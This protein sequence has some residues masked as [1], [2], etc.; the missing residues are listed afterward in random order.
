MLARSTPTCSTFGLSSSSEPV[1]A[2][3]IDLPRVYSSVLFSRNLNACSYVRF[4]KHTYDSYETQRRSVTHRAPRPVPYI[5]SALF[6]PASTHY[7]AVE[8]APTYTSSRALEHSL[9]ASGTRLEHRTEWHHAEGVKY[10]MAT[11]WRAW[12]WDVRRGPRVTPC[13]ADLLSHL[14]RP[15]RA[16]QLMVR[17][18]R[19]V[20]HLVLEDVFFPGH[21]CYLANA[22]FDRYLELYQ[23]VAIATE[24]GDAAIG[25]RLLGMVLEAGLVE[26]R[27]GLVVPTFRDGEGKRVAQI[28]MEHIREAVLGAGLVSGREVDNFVAELGRLADD[29]RTLMSIAPTFQVWAR[30]AGA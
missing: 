10:A 14:P 19:P 1:S 21:I 20:G 17:A 18:V 27:V 30:R 2:C 7:K 26:V 5:V 29:D 25:A 9:A 23:A 4:T 3:P 28:T 12:G 6:Q 16:V 13:E 24:G 15:Q 8:P 22:A 11:G